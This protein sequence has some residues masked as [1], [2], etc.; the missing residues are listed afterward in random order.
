ME[1]HEELAKDNNALHRIPRLSH[2]YQKK[3][4]LSVISLCFSLLKTKWD[5]LSERYVLEHFGREYGLPGDCSKPD[6]R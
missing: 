3:D 5:G 4:E 2:E 1:F 6:V